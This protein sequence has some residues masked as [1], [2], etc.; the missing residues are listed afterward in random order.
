MHK[1]YGLWL[2]ISAA[3]I[4]LGANPSK[5]GYCKSLSGEM[6]GFGQEG[7]RIYAKAALDRE[8]AAWETRAS[9]K[10]KP[11]DRKMA[12]KDYIKFLNEFEC[13]ETA[14]VCR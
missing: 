13:K 5:A 4:V 7:T 12:C 2:A 3:A 6:V 8:I 14:V 11:K 1:T 10:A 9:R